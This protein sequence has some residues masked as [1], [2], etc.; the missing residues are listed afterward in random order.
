MFNKALAVY[1]HLLKEGKFKDI[2]DRIKRLKSIDEK[3]VLSAN[4]TNNDKTLLLENVATTPTLDRYEI[5]KELGR[6]AMGTV[7]LGRDP[8]INREVAIKT[9]KYV[10]VDQ[11]K[12]S[13]I[14]K[15]FFREAEAAGKLSHPNI[16]TIFDVGEDYDMAYIAMELVS[17]KDLTGYC[18]KG[19]LLSVKRVLK[20]IYSVAKALAYAH[21]H[22][23]VHRDIKPSN[24]MLLKNGE[25]KVTDF[26]IAQ[27]MSSQKT[28]SRF[29]YGTPNYMSPEQIS[30]QK[31]DGRSDLFS[32]GIVFYELLTGEKP[33]KGDNINNLLYAITSANYIRLSRIKPNM[34]RFCTR[35]VDKLLT[36]S[37]AQRIQSADKLVEQIDF[38][39]KKLD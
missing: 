23:V 1:N 25:I 6:G 3:V 39:L 20:M 36:K 31:V 33:F 15:R 14:K 30:G 16:I 29:I 9:I 27:F 35:I 37:A 4:T 32:L 12:L 8:A 18:R 10:D 5:L 11:N 28:H 38:C 7:Y 19:R 34:P 26:G 24:I 13:G 2:K 21:N 22:G 17:G